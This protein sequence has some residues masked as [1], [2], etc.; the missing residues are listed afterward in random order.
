MLFSFAKLGYDHIKEIDK[1]LDKKYL[2]KDRSTS[3]F[4][5]ESKIIPTSSRSR[6]H[7]RFM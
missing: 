6:K 2:K 7:K 4:H 1:Y 3:V 5:V